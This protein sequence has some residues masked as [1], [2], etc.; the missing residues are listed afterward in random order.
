MR[1]SITLLP[2]LFFIFSMHLHAQ[3]LDQHQWKNRLIVIFCDHPDGVELK[4]QLNEF[5]NLK[6]GLQERKLLI[7]QISE[8]KFRQGI[9][10]QGVWQKTS[11]DLYTNLKN[12]NSPFEVLLIGLDGGVKLREKKPVSSQ[13]LFQ[14]ID[15]MPMRR[16]EI[17]RKKGD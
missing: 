3:D 14:L 5:H 6:A 10:D 12:D 7:Y 8:G 1:S 13:K 2:I 15:S 11:N 16:S 17:K 4:K 9:K